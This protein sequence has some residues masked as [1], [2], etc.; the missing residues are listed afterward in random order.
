VSSFF[1]R[2]PDMRIILAGTAIPRSP[3]VT[4]NRRERIESLLK[5]PRE[6]FPMRK[7]RPAALAAARA[8]LVGQREKTHLLAL[9][10]GSRKPM[11]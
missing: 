4:G 11:V 8:D 9:R 1:Q 3:A 5:D 7:R 2:G 10:T 6:R